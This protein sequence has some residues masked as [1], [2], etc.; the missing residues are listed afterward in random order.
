MRGGLRL[1]GSV[2]GA[3]TW[4]EPPAFPAARAPARHARHADASA[5]A[6]RAVTASAAVSSTDPGGRALPAACARL[7][8]AATT[9][10]VS[11]SKPASQI[12]MR[13]S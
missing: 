5:S 9:A 3:A 8:R 2:R 11:G 13:W 6:W 10:H 4:V 1:V 7:S 12:R